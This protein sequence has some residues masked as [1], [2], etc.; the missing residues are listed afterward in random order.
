MGDEEMLEPCPMCDAR[1]VVRKENG[2]IECKS[3][4]A[5]LFTP[6]GLLGDKIM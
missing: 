3:C 1:S 4:G 6:K 2:S 5:I